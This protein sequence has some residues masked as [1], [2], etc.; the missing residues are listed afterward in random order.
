VDNRVLLLLLVRFLLVRILL[1]LTLLMAMMMM[2]MLMMTRATPGVH[3][4][5]LHLNPSFAGSTSS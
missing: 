4:E 2:M 3:Q 1:N 5:T